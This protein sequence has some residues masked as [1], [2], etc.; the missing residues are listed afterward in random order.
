MASLLQFKLCY[1]QA[2]RD[3][4]QTSS[5]CI[6]HLHRY[7]YTNPPHIQHQ[8][9]H[10]WSISP[11]GAKVKGIRPLVFYIE[12]KYNITCYRPNDSSSYYQQL[13]A[14]YNGIQRSILC[15]GGST[16]RLQ[17]P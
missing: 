11:N 14:I 8:I 16:P 10:V 1:Q 12:D 7:I 4:H 9:Q 15:S 17:Q 13:G 6:A 3:T 5:K 2:T